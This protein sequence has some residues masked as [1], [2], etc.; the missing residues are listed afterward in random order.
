MKK[1]TL[2]LAALLLARA[3]HA[4]DKPTPAYDKGGVLFF[5]SAGHADYSVS[6]VVNGRTETWSCSA[7]SDTVSCG[8]GGG[9]WVARLADGRTGTVSAPLGFMQHPNMANPLGTGLD[10]PA[11]KATVVG[12]QPY[13]AFKYREQVGFKGYSRDG[14]YICTDAGQGEACYGVLALGK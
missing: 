2:I 13:Y 5:V 4:K 1:I 9:Y 8:N 12:G 7:G 11:Y 10:S 6:F 14:A 3:A